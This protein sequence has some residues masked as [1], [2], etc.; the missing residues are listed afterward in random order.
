M[1]LAAVRIAVAGDA[2]AVSELLHAYHES[3]EAEKVAHD[4]QE[5]GPLAP[6]Y[7]AEIDAAAF[8]GAEVLLAEADSRVIGMVV[9]R[10]DGADA[11]VKRLW[12]DPA[13][14]G[15]GAGSALIAEAA[16]RAMAAGAASLRLSVWDWRHDA[17]G[18]YRSRGFVEVASWEMR[19]RL[20]C[21]RMPLR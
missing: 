6:A 8:P 3:T 9:V 18:L 16:R 2:A 1:S 14:R 20:V 12:V 21:L 4:L 15:A 7:A 13:A 17:L 11:E 19:E 5:F 10:V